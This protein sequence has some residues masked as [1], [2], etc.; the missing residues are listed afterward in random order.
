MLSKRL[1]LLSPILGL[2]SMTYVHAANA[3]N[4]APTIV[5]APRTAVSTDRFYSFT[6]TAGD[7]NGDRLAFGVSGLPRWAHFDKRTGRL[8]GRPGSGDI[9]K[10]RA[11][12]IAVSDGR[13]TTN[14]PRFT[15][16]V[17]ATVNAAPSISGSPPT[18]TTAGSFYSFQPAAVDAEGAALTFSVLNKP[19]WATFDTANG[20]LQG[21]PVAA[22]LGTYSN[23]TVRVTDGATTASLPTFAITVSDPGAAG[24]ATLSWQP[25][26]QYVDGMPLQ[27]LAGFKIRYGTVADRLDQIVTIP[28]PGITSAMIE[29]LTAG[30]WY[31]AVDAY[32]RANV[33]SNLSNVVQKTIL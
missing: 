19:V 20:R 15:I 22:D 33:E 9:G 10:S 30:T 14:L 26:T 1:R 12:S 4:I 2:G 3:N 27:D 8:Y 5:G 13:L 32:T 24:A 31:F 25:P 17:R 18:S 16:T 11:I 21:T 7:A 6:P 23:V 29:S 28:N